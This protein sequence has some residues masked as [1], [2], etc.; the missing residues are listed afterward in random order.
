MFTK[1]LGILAVVF[2]VCGG[3]RA[4]EET[5]EPLTDQEK[6]TFQKQLD[7]R[8]Q[9]LTE[10]IAKSPAKVDLYSQRGD[11]NFFRGKFKAAVGDYEKM[12]DLQPDLENSHWRR[13]IAYFYA[14]QY[15]DAA[16]QFEIYHSFDDVDR[17]NGIWRFLSQA[18]AFGI[19]KAREGL[20]KYKKDDREPFPDVYK[21]F[22]GELTGDQVIAKI[23]AADISD[24]DRETRLF[25]AE[26]YVGLNEA[27]SDHPQL[28]EQHLREAVKNNWGANAGGGPGY[29]WQVG[30]V[31]YDVLKGRA[32]DKR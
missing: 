17:E 31:H 13:G 7:E 24:A 21:M 25:Y 18:K 23:K 2:V 16:H 32:K 15:K 19:K 10:K 11:A 6:A 12:I 8:I 9:S 5:T 14:E 20:L 26:L 1:W 27:V 4:A 29:M 30:R 28:A 22:A 3:L